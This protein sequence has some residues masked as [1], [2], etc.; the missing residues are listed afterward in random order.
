MQGVPV[1]PCDD[2]SDA[3]MKAFRLMVTW[4]EWDETVLALELQ[5]IPET[6][7]DLSLPGFDVGEIDKLLA[8][9]DDEKANDP[10]PLPKTPASRPGDLWLLGP[11]R[12]LLC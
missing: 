10:P 6:D 8:L 5:A 3:Q 2:W 9:E 4:A 1:I 12:V 11:H 7:L